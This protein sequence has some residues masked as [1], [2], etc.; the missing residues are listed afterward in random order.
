MRKTKNYI[1][2]KILKNIDAFVEGRPEQ[3]SDIQPYGNLVNE[4]PFTSGKFKAKV[5]N[6]LV[7]PQ[8]KIIKKAF[9]GYF[10]QK[11]RQFALTQKR[12][13][14]IEDSLERIQELLENALVI[15]ADQKDRKDK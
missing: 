1:T 3:I 13:A 12:L 11:D 2:D 4:Y 14:D 8:L 15:D 5:A 6:K 9:A 7:H 10:W